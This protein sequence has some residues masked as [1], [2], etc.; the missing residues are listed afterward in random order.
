MFA[1][2]LVCGVGAG[3]VGV[4]VHRVAGVSP[5][6]VVFGSG[7]GFMLVLAGVI[8]HRLTGCVRWCCCIRQW[9]HW[10]LCWC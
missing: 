1:L 10:V 7:G 6:I 3:G 4:V 5:F 2:V 8:V 9:R